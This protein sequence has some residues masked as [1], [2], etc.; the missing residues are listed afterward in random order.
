M[1]YEVG[2][3]GPNLVAP[4]APLNTSQLINQPIPTTRSKDSHVKFLQSAS[5]SFSHVL[6]L[7]LIQITEA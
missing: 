7:D 6:N 1:P 4:K 5:V 2:A 3:T